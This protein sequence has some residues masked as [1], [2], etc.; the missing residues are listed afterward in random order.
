MSKFENREVR[1]LNPE[2]M[3]KVVG[4]AYKP[5]PPK[6]GFIIYKIQNGDTKSSICEQF[7]C[8]ESQLS[9]WNPQ[10]TNWTFLR[11]GQEIYIKS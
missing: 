7:W 11:A 6:E 5:L 8:A 1:E 10:I 2:E 9:T 3:D 4:G